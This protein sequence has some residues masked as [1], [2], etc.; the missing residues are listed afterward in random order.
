MYGMNG[1]WQSPAAS[2]AA[3]P[4]PRAQPAD[5][6]TTM[7]PVAPWAA[8]AG[9]LGA[10]AAY[11]LVDPGGPRADRVVDLALD[12]VMAI[13]A[14]LCLLR[15]VRYS[16]ERPAW[17]FIG[18]ALTG[19]AL[20]DI[21]YA[22]LYA[23]GDPPVPSISDPFWLSFLAFGGV[24]LVLLARARFHAAD[25]GRLIESGQAALVVAAFGMI[26]L[27]YPA[28]EHSTG[29]DVKV[30]MTLAYPTGDIVLMSVILAAFTLSGFR[31]GRDW[32][33]L[34]AG[35]LLF[36][37]CDAARFLL[38]IGPGYSSDTLLEAGWPAAHLLIAYAA[39][40]PP[41]PV[42]AVE[43][44][45]W[46]TAILPEV[47]SVIS[48]AIQLGAVFGAL[49][50][51]YPAAR[52]LI[53]VAQT[54]LLIKLADSPGSYRRARSRDALTGLGNRYA[55]G[56][57]MSRCFR[58]RRASVLVMCEVVEPLVLA[59]S[60]GRARRD[61]L[62][63]SLGGALAEQIDTRATLYRGE[64]GDFLVLAPLAEWGDAERVISVTLAAFEECR[65]TTVSVR[66]GAVLIPDEA[67]DPT[68]A[69]AVAERRLVSAVSA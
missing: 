28:V 16:A 30:A 67:A 60:R 19:S 52:T 50:G 51:K 55:L 26:L 41:T 38:S 39:W 40:M 36:T 1:T 27:F 2:L 46:R 44:D 69:L 24:G 31:P 68:E 53:I 8:L 3:M 29:G 47:V 6:P 35:F 25:K 62:L 21:L 63:V 17:L 48:I 49:P 64:E 13:A 12:G 10:L 58:R 37:A 57:D 5:A 4:A 22:V 61:E 7:P 45:D 9:V 33:V 65:D 59:S 20:G 23:P 32:A 18:L 66:Y 43:K 34:G 14:L 42:R 15:A 56:H 54:L 11:K